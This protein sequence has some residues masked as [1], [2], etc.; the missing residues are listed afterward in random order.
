MTHSEERS[1]AHLLARLFVGL[2]P[3]QEVRD[4]I[5]DDIQRWTWP[6]GAAPVRGDKLH[7]TLHFLGFVAR[8]RVPEL[9]QALHVGFEPFE[10]TLD[11]GEVWPGGIAVLRP[12]AAPPALRELHRGLHRA[13]GPLGVRSARHHLKPHITLA[14]RAQ[15]AE[16]PV[17]CE[18]IHWSVRDYVLVESDLRPPTQYIVRGRYA[19]PDA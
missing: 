8:E 17:Q 3:P 4:A 11:R 13:L 9:V 15:G 12:S 2:W 7:M 18:A 14:R 6:R 1:V 10:L 16:P 5:L 19:S